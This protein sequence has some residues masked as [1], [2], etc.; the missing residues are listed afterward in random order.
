VL[1]LPPPPEQPP[2]SDIGSPPDSPTPRPRRMAPR[3]GNGVYSD[4]GHGRGGG[5]G[6]GH[7]QGA[8]AA[9]RTMSPRMQAEMT[10]RAY[11]PRAMS[12]PERGPTPPVRAYKLVPINEPGPMAGN[13][14]T[15]GGVGAH[16][17]HHHHQRSHYSDTEAPLPPQRHSPPSPAPQDLHH[18]PQP[19]PRPGDPHA[20]D[21][22]DG[23]D[24][25]DEYVGESDGEQQQDCD[26]DS[27]VAGEQDES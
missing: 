16:H 10:A 2:P 5:G 14:A 26:M 27:N 18:R 20:L 21:G 22:D 3:G 17:H 9:C 7:P 12:E 24:M 1:Y 6:G 8:S 13:A 4:S 23:A 19:R 25:V 11:S 15:L